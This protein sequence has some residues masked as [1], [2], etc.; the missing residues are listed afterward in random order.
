MDSPPTDPNPGPLFTVDDYQLVADAIYREQ[1]RRGLFERCHGIPAPAD[2][3][4]DRLGDLARR[5][6]R[7]LETA[8]GTSGT[9]DAAT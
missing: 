8:G 9:P 2:D 1:D 7:Y 4:L 5:I 6:G 3:Q